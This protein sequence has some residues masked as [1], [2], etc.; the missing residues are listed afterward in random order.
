MLF[1]QFNTTDLHFRLLQDMKLVPI[2]SF[3]KKAFSLR[4]HTY[5]SSEN[6]YIK[7]TMFI[8][9]VDTQWKGGSSVSDFSI[10]YYRRTTWLRCTDT[11][12]YLQLYWW[13]FHSI[14][15]SISCF[16][17]YKLKDYL[18]SFSNEYVSLYRHNADIKHNTVLLS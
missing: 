2:I 9:C 12:A 10:I 4:R 7:K 15:T 13:F 6:V 18:L 1:I 8:N 14:V 11:S 3:V 5:Q 17:K 16:P